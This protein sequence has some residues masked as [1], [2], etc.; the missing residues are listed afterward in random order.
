MR[1]R[2]ISCKILGGRR[3]S[4]LTLGSLS[5]SY[6]LQDIVLSYKSCVVAKKMEFVLQKVSILYQL[7]KFLSIKKYKLCPTITTYMYVCM[8][9]IIYNVLYLTIKCQYLLSTCYAFCTEFTNKKR[10]SKNW[11]FKYQI[12]TVTIRFILYLFTNYKFCCIRFHP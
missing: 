7:G 9:Y 5:L 8:F 11:F 6:Y 2:V 1:Q 12:L 3:N 4:V 10:F